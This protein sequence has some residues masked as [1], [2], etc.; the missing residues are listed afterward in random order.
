LALAESGRFRLR[1]LSALVLAPPV[2]AAAWLGGNFLAVVVILAAAGMGWEWGRLTGCHNAIATALVLATSVPSLAMAFSAGRTAVV[3]AFAGAAAIWAA[4]HAMPSATRGWAALGTVWIA[5]PCV[6]CL[7]LAGEAGVGRAAILWLF[8]T[9]WASD[10]GAYAAGRA[11]GGPR[12][13]P[14]LSPNKTWAGVAGGLIAAGL[15]GWAAAGLTGAPALVVAP[16]GIAIG[17]AAQVG[18][19]VESLAKRRFGVK[20]SGSLIPGH[21]G[22]LDRLDGMMTAAALQGLLTVIAGASPLAWRV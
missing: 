19:L 17:L 8:A 1:L 5:L 21:G 10:S 12:L 9:V 18:D 11:L 13:A 2:L 15:V 22:L 7:W 14:R 6:A 4:S 3:L 20:D 16:A